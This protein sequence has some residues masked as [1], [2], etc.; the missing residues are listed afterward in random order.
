MQHSIVCMKFQLEGEYDHVTHASYAFGWQGHGPL[1]P[2][3]KITK[4]WKAAFGA[5]L[6]SGGHTMREK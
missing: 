1:G 5:R 4:C 2:T 3:P 6:S